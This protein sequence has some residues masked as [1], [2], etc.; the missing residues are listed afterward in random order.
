MTTGSPAT[1]RKARED[2]E[3]NALD[4]GALLG[5]LQSVALG[6]FSVRLPGDR[7]GIEG[8]IADTF[9]DIVAANQRM[10]EE[11]QRAGKAVGKE[12]QTRKR[13]NFGRRQGAWHEM[14]GSVNTLIDD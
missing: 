11:L 3:S 5:A 7:V 4:L 2:S 12:G 14:E 10:A 8:K 6:D 9:N 1:P 13:V